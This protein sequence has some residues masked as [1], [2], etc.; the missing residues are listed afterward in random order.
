MS[1]YKIMTFDGGGVLGVVTMR[2][3]TRL[4]EQKSTLLDDVQL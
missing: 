3:L 1:T 4:Y 2:L